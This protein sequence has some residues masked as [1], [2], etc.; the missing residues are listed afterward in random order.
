MLAFLKIVKV[1][2]KMQ[3]KYIYGWIFYG[4]TMIKNKI[5][6]ILSIA[7]LLLVFAENAY[8]ETFVLNKCWA[9]IEKNAYGDKVKSFKEF[10]KIKKIKD[11]I[12][13]VDTK[14]KKIVKRYV[15]PG[16]KFDP[17]D[18]RQKLQSFN[19]IDT[20]N[21]VIVGKNEGYVSF[22]NPGGYLLIMV[23]LKNKRAGTWFSEEDQNSIDFHLSCKTY[24]GSNNSI[25]KSILKMLN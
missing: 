24:K 10:K 21:N 19:I 8:A 23:D 13:K 2:L 16:D 22:K 12:I 7:F 5:K 1:R 9:Y 4:H 17:F 6:K 15:L 20:S 18:P 25:L 14:K 11:Y 3:N